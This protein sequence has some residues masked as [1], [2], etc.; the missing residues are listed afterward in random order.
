MKHPLIIEAAKFA[1]AAHMGQLRK[2][3]LDP[4][5]FHPMRVAGLVCLQPLATEAMIAAAW[6]HDVLE[7]C[8]QHF[9]NE[10]V[11]NFP[12]EVV[13]LVEELTNPS[14]KFPHLRRD[15]RKLMDRHH[16]M[17]V[18]P[19]AKF[20]K[21][22]DRYDNLREMDLAPQN[23]VQIYVEES[24]LLLDAIKLRGNDHMRARIEAECAKLLRNPNP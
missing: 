15:E 6:L 16:L 21:L 10:L 14:K 8:E 22:C 5:I 19:E 20:I 1:D 23:F 3:T 18:S 4:Y 2:Y 12:Y 11:V 24:L 17:I 7:D 9:R 13:H